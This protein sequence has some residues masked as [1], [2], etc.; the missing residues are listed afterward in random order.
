M[1]FINVECV[2]QNSKQ[3]AI[4]IS[5]EDT[6]IGI[7]ESQLKRVFDKFTQTDVSTTRKFGG[8]G[9]GLAISRKLTQAM[10]SDIQVTSEPGQGSIFW[11]DVTL[12]VVMAEEGDQ[13]PK[14]NTRLRGYKGPR[15]K[16]LVADDKHLNR[17]VL[18]SLLEPLGL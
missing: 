13:K 2:E 14:T 12:P 11:L 10:G 5:V 8:T 15:R 7:P 3:A 9:L 4:N 1:F 6:G 17:L 18:I 16:V